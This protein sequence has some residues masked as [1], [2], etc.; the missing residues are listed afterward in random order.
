MKWMTRL[1]VVAVFL[2]GAVAGVALGMKLERDRM[3]KVQRQSPVSLT[4]R[5]LSHIS[6]ELKLQPEQQEKLRKVLNGVQPLLTAAE[7]ARR[8]SIVAALE[9]VRTGAL[10]FL[11]SSQV[12]RYEAIHRKMKEQF[13]PAASGEPSA[14]AAAFGA[15]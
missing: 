9:V 6:S 12:E 8:R 7:N 4:E 3:L 13:R 10:V 1:L 2:L 5:A 11:D 15:W 14:S